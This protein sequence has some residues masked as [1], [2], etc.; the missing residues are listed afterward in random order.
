MDTTT[1]IWNGILEILHHILNVP[2]DALVEYDLRY[3]DKEL[4]VY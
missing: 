3:N 2:S 4:P 1:G